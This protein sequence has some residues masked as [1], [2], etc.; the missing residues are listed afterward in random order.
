MDDKQTAAR[1]RER[2]QHAVDRAALAAARARE[3]HDE[4]AHAGT[5]E[6]GERFEREADLHE[7]AAELHRQAAKIQA[8]HA[9]EHS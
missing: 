6:L 9:K 8:R 7:R 2:E 3:A 1:A 4:A 5:P